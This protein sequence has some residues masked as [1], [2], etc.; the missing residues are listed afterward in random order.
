[1]S[2]R[3]A[4]GVAAA[5]WAGALVGDAAPTPIV[6]VV[7]IV[8]VAARRRPLALC[9]TFLLATSLLASRSLAGLDHS[10]DGPFTG[11]VTLATDPERTVDDRLRFEVATAQGRLLAEV[12]SPTAVARLSEHLAGDRAVVAGRV[13]PF[14][15][16][17][18]WVRSRHL[19]GRLTIEAV[20]A[21]G[22]GPPAAVAANR[23]RRLLDDG[24]ASLPSD[25]RALLAGLVLGDDRAQPP[26][27]T[28]DFRAAGLTHLLAVSGQNV[29]FVLAVAGPALRRLRLWPRFVLAIGVIAA[30][31][32]V[33]RF[34]PSVVRAA[35]VA[36]VALYAQTIGRPSGGLRHLAIAVCLLLLVDPLLVHSLGF[37][38]SVAASLGVLLLGPRL[39]ERLPGPT[40]MRTGL[41]VT[42][43]AQ[44]AVAPVLVPV[45]GPMPLA[46]LPANVAAG[47][48]AGALMV[49]GL[50]AGTVA[51]AVGG[52]LAWLLHR[53]SAV[54]LR[55]LEGIAATG[56]SLPL[57]RVDLRHVVVLAVAAGLAAW[58]GRRAS[59]PGFVAA[60][61]LGV[62]ALVSPVVTPAPAGA[63][64]AGHDATVWVDG[65]V[66][67][68]DLGPRADP[69][70][71]L[72]ALRAADVAAVGLVVL[73]S[74]MPPGL[75]ILDAIEARF[76][77]GAAVG[78]PGLGSDRVT[79]PT[80]DLRIR[81]GRLTIRI[82]RP[83]PP[84]RASIGWASPERSQSAAVGSPGARHA[85]S[86]P[87]RHHPPGRG[88]RADR[89]GRRRS[90]GACSGGVRRSPRRGADHGPRGRRTGAAAD[91]RR[92]G[93]RR[94]RRPRGRSQR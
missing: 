86:K 7:A 58:S 27:L 93:A 6:A 28:A 19:A 21:T 18:E 90:K 62:I 68:V 33:T 75:E 34:E 53:P 4:V 40:W 51:G 9:A 2:D 78:P 61:V 52:P 5:A 57:G 36:G 72:D 94:S 37:R 63:R 12:R 83:G 24:A 23:F 84:L 54:G 22:P 92:S 70:D 60:A 47:P 77:V 87:L 14:A 39:A 17:S 25:Q 15:H 30:F 46:A 45:F 59:A 82:D 31:A 66:A 88:R 3:W 8:A 73:R 89:R 20:H 80:G 50:T 48:I 32:L 26:E 35:F 11:A 1:M 76:P 81:V 56:A 42:A 41:A 29:L 16:M 91:G 38:L 55:V 85:G 10:P 71:V 43:G 67:V 13:S 64:S 49:W 79:V 44:V 65:P 74:A 69:V